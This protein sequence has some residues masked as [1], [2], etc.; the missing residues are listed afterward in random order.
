MFPAGSFSNTERQVEVAIRGSQCRRGPHDSNSVFPEEPLVSGCDSQ[1][2]LLTQTQFQG[3]EL[4]SCSECSRVLQKAGR[5]LMPMRGKAGTISRVSHDSLRFPGCLHGC[6]PQGQEA[7][8]SKLPVGCGWSPP[9]VPATG[10]VPRAEGLSL[11][12]LLWAT[13]PAAQSKAPAGGAPPARSRQPGTCWVCAPLPLPGCR[14]LLAEEGER[15]LGVA[16]ATCPVPGPP[17]PTGGDVCRSCRGGGPGLGS[18]RPREPG[19]GLGKFAKG[20]L[21]TDSPL[22]L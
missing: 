20:S 14:L 19:L 5:T 10:F 21:W 17:L 11:S 6:V 18:R 7:D 16:R 8:F 9:S 22:P 12:Q 4:A 15:T 3:H 1:A 2:P 13:F